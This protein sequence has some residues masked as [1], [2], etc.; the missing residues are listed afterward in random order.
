MEQPRRLVKSFVQ[1]YQAPPQKVFR[2][3]CPVREY[4]WI[5]N[6]Q[7]RMIWSASGVAED[8]C[9]FITDFPDTGREVWVVSRFDPEQAIE[10]VRFSQ[11]DKIIRLDIHLQDNGDGTTTARWRHTYTSL[12][13]AGNLFIEN[14][15]DAG[16]EK[17]MRL[18]EAMLNHYLNTG[19]M[20]KGTAEF[21][22]RGNAHDAHD[23]PGGQA[24]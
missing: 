17:E 24:V 3:L 14:L 4:D 15:A 7:C 21:Y 1:N 23:Q 12:N 16:Y 5:E 6:W 19:T 8:N 11:E 20:L 18:L 9:I 22:H 10:F 2:L 13:S